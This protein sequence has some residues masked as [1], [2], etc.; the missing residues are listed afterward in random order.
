MFTVESIL[1]TKHNLRAVSDKCYP[2]LYLEVR[3][4]IKKTK[5]KTKHFVYGRFGYNYYINS[6]QQVLVPHP[7]TP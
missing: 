6:N 7:E 2:C 3:R 5:K 4:L 1:Q